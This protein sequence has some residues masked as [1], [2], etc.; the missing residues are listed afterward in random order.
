MK[1][2]LI[3]NL[4]GEMIV[5]GQR[6]GSSDDVTIVEEWN[7][8]PLEMREWARDMANT[9]LP[10]LIADTNNQA[11]ERIRR[12]EEI[13][14]SLRNLESLDGDKIEEQSVKDNTLF[15][16]GMKVSPSTDGLAEVIDSATEPQ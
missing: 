8:L 15:F 12:I 3:R 13:L 6:T 4:L 5:F 9:N 2:E 10:L 7:K 14:E 1:A 16:P 11:E